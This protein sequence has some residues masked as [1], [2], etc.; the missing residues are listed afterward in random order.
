MNCL[1]CRQAEIVDGFTSITFERDEFKLVIKHVPA[2]I[3]PNCGDALV[4][5]DVTIRLMNEAEDAS[6]Q[7]MWD[8]VR[9]Y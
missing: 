2:Q 9:E 1:I 7:G 8:D 5:E 6:E 3:C 4:D